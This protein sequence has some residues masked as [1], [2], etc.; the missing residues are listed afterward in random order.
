MSRTWR[1][2]PRE[3]EEGNFP[4]KVR[5]KDNHGCT[6][7]KPPEFKRKDNRRYRS[8]VNDKLNALSNKRYDILDSEERLFDEVQFPDPKQYREWYW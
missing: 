7:S 1:Q 6:Y 5:D 8:N 4:K 3:D 2:I